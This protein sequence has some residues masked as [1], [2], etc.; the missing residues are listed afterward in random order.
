MPGPEVILLLPSILSHDPRGPR[1]E[2][3]R[4]WVLK[5]AL[6]SSL[7]LFYSVSGLAEEARTPQSPEYHALEPKAAGSIG[8]G[9]YLEGGFLLHFLRKRQAHLGFLPGFQNHS[10]TD[11][12]LKELLAIRQKCLAYGSMSHLKVYAKSWPPH[13]QCHQI[14]RSL[15][16]HKMLRSI[17]NP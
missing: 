14:L 7:C 13:F 12:E 16:F 5:A 10:T 11:A 8:K 6:L 17:P 2:A 9:V 3:Q 1:K 4:H 15:P